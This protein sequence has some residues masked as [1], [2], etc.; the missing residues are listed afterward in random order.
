VQARPFMWGIRDKTNDKPYFDEF[1]VHSEPKELEYTIDGDSTL[2]VI[3][4]YRAPFDVS[5]GILVP[6]EF[7]NFL[8]TAPVDSGVCCCGDRMDDHSPHDHSPVDQWDYSLGNWLRSIE[9]QNRQRVQ[10][11]EPSVEI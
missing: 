6:Q 3:P 2:E 8:K 5:E 1:C 4:L 10:Q 9:V 7:I 11:A